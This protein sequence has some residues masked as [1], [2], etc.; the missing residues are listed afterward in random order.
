MITGELKGRV[1]R[2]WT[3]FWNNG[4][5]NPIS[6]IEQLSFLV[7]MRRLDEEETRGERAARRLGQPFQGRFGPDEQAWRWSQLKLQSDPD[8]Q[9]RLAR[10]AFE[11]MKRLPGTEGTPYAQHMK[12]AV[13]LIASPTLVNAAVRQIDEIFELIRRQEE[14]EAEAGGIKKDLKGDLYE[15]MLSKLSQAGTNGQFRTPRHI[16]DMMV[17]FRRPTLQDDLCDPAFGTAGFLVGAAEYLRET[18]G[19]ELV[20]DRAAFQRF[21]GSMFTGFDFDGTMLRI[22][23][24]NLMLHGV[25]HPDVRRADALREDM[26]HVRD[27][28]TLILANPPFKGSV[29]MDLVA[30]DLLRALGLARQKRSRKPQALLP[31]AAADGLAE[32]KKAPGAK[33]ELLFLA[34]ML[35]ALKVGGR[36]AVIVPDGVLFGSSKAHVAIRKALV[37]EQ[38]LE[39]VL[40][41]PSGVFKPYAGVST[42]VL[43]FTRTDAGGT[44]K[45]W[46]YDMLADGYSLDD[47]RQPVDEND[48]PDAIARWRT[49]DEEQDLD[50]TAKSFFVGREEIVENGYDLSINRYKQVKH[51]VV[52]WERPG[53]ILERLMGLEEEIREGLVEL[54]GMVG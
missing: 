20:T 42:A 5:S 40:S 24:M 48:I 12:D 15:Y 25:E 8:E 30:E 3:T 28:F 16:I 43:L 22:G 46:F 54:R 19:P 14:A 52:A 51:E 10:L 35:R 37:D 45:V 23:S 38:L 49:R 4:I 6:V 13:F 17:Q 21:Q 50:R 39:G 18:F 11:H 47:K 31:L 34:Q 9:L 32:E 1:D 36:A 27:R 41:M 44:D 33:T 26:K 2:L 7:F 29:D 53:V